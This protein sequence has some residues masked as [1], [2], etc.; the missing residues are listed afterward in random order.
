MTLRED[1]RYHCDRC[2]RDVGNADVRSATFFSMVDPDNPVE[3]V[4]GHLCT[5]A[6]GGRP[7]YPNGCTGRVL[8]PGTLADWATWRRSR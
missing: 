8:G 5:A 2:G 7:G 6:T 4:R 3:V 1:G